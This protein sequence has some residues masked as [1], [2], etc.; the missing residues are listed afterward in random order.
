MGA[1]YGCIYLRTRDRAR[2]PV[3][4]ATAPGPARAPR[5]ALTPA[6]RGGPARKSPPPPRWRCELCPGGLR[7]AGL[8]QGARAAECVS[9]VRRPD[10][11]QFL[12]QPLG[13]L[14]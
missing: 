14:A 13:P 9:L 7:L 8:R 6:R 12:D 2:R 10:G 4:A 5:R 11:G 1:F 3:G